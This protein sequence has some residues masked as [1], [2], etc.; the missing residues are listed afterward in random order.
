MY[1]LRKVWFFRVVQTRLLNIELLNLR[2]QNLK[3]YVKQSLFVQIRKNELSSYTG[4][5]DIRLEWQAPKGLNY[6]FFFSFLSFL[7]IGIR[8]PG[9]I[10]W[11]KLLSNRADIE[12]W[13][14]RYRTLTWFI[15]FRGSGVMGPQSW[16][17][18]WKFPHVISEMIQY[19]EIYCWMHR[20]E[21]ETDIYAMYIDPRVLQ[22]LLKANRLSSEK[23]NQLRSMTLRRSNF[24]FPA[25]SSNVWWRIYHPRSEIDVLCPL[26]AN[27]MWHTV[28]PKTLC[29]MT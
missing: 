25:R 10:I 22:L 9:H 28:N 11:S 21:S 2:W 27:T 15:R 6:F 17:I 12:E 5:W 3:F 13:M 23:R 4:Y 14:K 29:L 20:S 19:F 8:C 26:N 24:G 16:K 1:S 18:F 7:N